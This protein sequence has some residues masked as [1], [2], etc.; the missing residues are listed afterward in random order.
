[1][2][3]EIPHLPTVGWV[4]LGVGVLLLIGGVAAIVLAGVSLARRPPPAP[5]APQGPRETP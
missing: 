5:P 3:V 1:V 4:L 2:A